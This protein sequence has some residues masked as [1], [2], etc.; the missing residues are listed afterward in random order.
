MFSFS[1]K[2]TLS[3]VLIELVKE[4]NSA[5]RNTYHH[6]PADDTPVLA[7][8]GEMSCSPTLS[9]VLS[10][11]DGDSLMA[12]VLGNHINITSY[13]CCCAWYRVNIHI[14]YIYITMYV[15]T[16]HLYIVN[17]S[18]IHDEDDCMMNCGTNTRRCVPH[19]SIVM[20]ALLH[21]HI[22]AM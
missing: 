18:I 14:I 19:M 7:H 8:V 3:A 17:K 20:C 11:P 10:Y 22:A 16:N 1:A 2:G 9:L 21:A 13:Y 5:I 15:I 6:L 12:V 4:Q